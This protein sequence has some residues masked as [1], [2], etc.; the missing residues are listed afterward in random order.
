VAGEYPLDANTIYACGL[1][2]GHSLTELRFRGVYLRCCWGGTRANRV[3]GS[4]RWLAEGLRETGARVE[5]AGV[6]PTPA[7]AFLART[8]GFRRAVV[9]SASHNPW[10]DNGIKLFGADGY[11]AGRCGG[12]G[13][14][15][16]NPSS[17]L[18]FSRSRRG[19]TDSGRGQR[20]APGRLYSVSPRLRAGTPIERF[21]H[22]G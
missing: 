11:K 20:C 8:H 21:A 3:S 18:A 13:H 4:R 17:C 2:L 7:V 14:G 15:R 5:S 16:R 22:C 10:Q 9:I 6:V 1:A 19:H 12:A